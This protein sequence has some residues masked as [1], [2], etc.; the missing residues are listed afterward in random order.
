MTL[1]TSGHVAA[2]PLADLAVADGV[3]SHDLSCRKCAYNLRGLPFSGLCPECATPVV[4][5]AQIDL[6]RFSDP[7]WVSQLAWGVTLLFVATLF[8]ML[9]T[10]LPF[11]FFL[12]RST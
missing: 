4:L 1:N 8:L 9:G 11:L 12:V 3:V 10:I 6:L 5:S 2:P 7:Q